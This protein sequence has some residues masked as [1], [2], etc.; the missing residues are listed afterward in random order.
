MFP[1][2]TEI[3]KKNNY[4]YIIVITIHGIVACIPVTKQIVDNTIR[5]QVIIVMIK[6]FFNSISE[7]L[8]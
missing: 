6:T 1:S 5:L 7:A 3:K 2:V 8:H 4:K